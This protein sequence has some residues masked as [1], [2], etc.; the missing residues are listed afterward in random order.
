[1]QW[2][3]CIDRVPNEQADFNIVLTESSWAGQEEE[4]EKLGDQ[5]QNDKLDAILCVAGGWAGG[6]ASSKGIKICVG[7]NEHFST[8]KIFPQTQLTAISQIPEVT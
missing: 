3:G 4:L 6:N 5:L 1:L 8:K 7:Q 2:V